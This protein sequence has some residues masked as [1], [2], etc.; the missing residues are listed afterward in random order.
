MTTPLLSLT[1][2]SKRDIV[3]AR[4]CA[5]RLAKLLGFQPSEQTRIAAAVFEIAYNARRTMGRVSL[6]FRLADARF[7]VFPASL[8]C[9][10]PK[11]P[12]PDAGADQRIPPK[13][14]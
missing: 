7:Q 4:Q 14:T 11:D 5:R 8:R 13:G 6:H 1:L 12:R 9:G 2:Q 10:Q 3:L